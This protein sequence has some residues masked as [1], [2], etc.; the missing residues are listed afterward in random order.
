MPGFT[1]PRD[2]RTFG[3]NKG[4]RYDELKTYEAPSS[5]AYEQH[6]VFLLETRYLVK[7][8]I[9]RVDCNEHLVGV[10]RSGDFPAILKKVNDP[11]GPNRDIMDNARWPFVKPKV[12][13][14]AVWWESGEDP[15]KLR[16]HGLNEEKTEVNVPTELLTSSSFHTIPQ[17]RGYHTSARVLAQHRLSSTSRQQRTRISLSSWSRPPKPSQ[18][19]H[20]DVVPSYYVERKRQRDSISERKEEEGGLM[21]ELSAGI[22]SEGVAA[23]TR[24]VPEKI[25][26]EVKELDGAV[27]HPSGFEPPTPETEFHPIASKTPTLDH[28][29]LT[30]YKLP[31]EE[32]LSSP[33]TEGDAATSSL[34]LGSKGLRGFHTSAPSQAI[35]V[36]HPSISPMPTEPPTPVV[37]E[38]LTASEA[39]AEPEEEV[40]FVVENEDGDEAVPFGPAT[41][42]KLALEEYE[43]EIRR[44]YKLELQEKPLFRPLLTLTFSTRPLALAVSRLSKGLPR[45]VPFYASL[46]NMDRKSMTS[47]SSRI[48][49]MRLQRMHNLTM[50]LARHLKGERGGLLGIR[51]NPEDKGRGVHGEGFEKP[52]DLDKRTIEVG[53]GEWYMLSEEIKEGYRLDAEEAGVQEAIKVVG[54]DERGMRM[55]GS[56]WPDQPNRVYV[57]SLHAAAMTREEMETLTK[58]QKRAKLD[59]WVGDD[60]H[61]KALERVKKH[62]SVL[63]P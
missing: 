36:D 46:D 13:K 7:K 56:N 59:E 15:N 39:D 27:R 23:S 55:D 37:Q 62:R 43:R 24:V 50:T 2:I 12:I 63:Y 10:C 25:P 31:W 45:G 17:H 19:A 57:P 11:Y 61:G 1:K 47:Y 22:L 29:V 32:V 42:P 9:G 40:E 44:Q 52:I 20:D 5:S 6:T 38:E 8:G 18:D 53:V 16:E 21:T 26:V 54:L 3:W 28:P 33:A 34:A 48:R 14:K 58:N 30:T 51:F 35:T 49:S 60:V 4:G 41:R